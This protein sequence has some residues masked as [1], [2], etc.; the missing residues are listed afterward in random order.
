MSHPLMMRRPIFLLR[1][2]SY[3]RSRWN[4]CRRQKRKTKV[5]VVGKTT[6]RK[7]A[8]SE[9]V[10]FGIWHLSWN[11][12]QSSLEKTPRRDLE[13]VCDVWCTPSYINAMSIMLYTRVSRVLYAVA[14][15]DRSY[16]HTVVIRVMLWWVSSYMI[17]HYRNVLAVIIQSGS[18]YAGRMVTTE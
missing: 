6:R 7:R 9:E 16:I 17:N 2:T 12:E 1:S 5:G 14:D 8:F 18:I 13:G 3:L 11:V 15:C 4:T 10:W